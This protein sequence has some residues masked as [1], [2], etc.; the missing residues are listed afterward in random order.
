MMHTVFGKLFAVR[1]STKFALAPKLQEV[2]DLAAAAGACA[3]RG[4]ER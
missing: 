1:R 4:Q 2:R 3:R